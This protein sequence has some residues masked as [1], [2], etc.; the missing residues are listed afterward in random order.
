M[1]EIEGNYI[2]I[3]DGTININHLIEDIDTEIL[4]YLEINNIECS[5]DDYQTLIKE[6]LSRIKIRGKKMTTFIILIGYAFG[7]TIGFIGSFTLGMKLADI[8]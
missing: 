4:N 5:Y 7:F 3:N 1:I 6:I 2:Y 8:F